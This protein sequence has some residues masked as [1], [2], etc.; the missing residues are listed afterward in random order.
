MD[1]ISFWS[2]GRLKDAEARRSEDGD[3]GFGGS[4]NRRANG[5]GKHKRKTIQLRI[6]IRTVK[7]INTQRDRRTLDV[8]PILCFCFG[9]KSLRKVQV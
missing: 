5:K 4:L 2:V 7:V 9:M 3:S 1:L 6:A 8:S